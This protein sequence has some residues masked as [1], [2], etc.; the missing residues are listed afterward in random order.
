MIKSYKI[1]VFIAVAVLGCVG[2]ALSFAQDA[3]PSSVTGWTS[4]LGQIQQE[5][6]QLL[7]VNDQLS[8]ER[9]RL[10]AELASLQQGLSVQREKN[11]KDLLSLEQRRSGAGP[12]GNAAELKSRI[13]EQER[14]VERKRADLARLKAREKN[15]ENRVALHK[16]NI[17]ELELEKKTLLLDKKVK[18]EVVSGK[19]MT[20]IQKLE[21]KVISQTEQEKYIRTKIDA[22]KRNAPP[23]VGDAEA[24]VVINA[25][26]KEQLKSLESKRQALNDAQ[27]QL[28][29]ERAALEK[30]KA[31]SKVLSASERRDALR[32]ELA[33]LKE[34]QKNIQIEANVKTEESVD[35]APATMVEEMKTI[36]AENKRITE[37]ITN[38]RENIAVLEYELNS[39]ERYRSEK[40]K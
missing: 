13:P 11:Q 34:K 16:L 26:L 23:Y 24:E 37:E 8:Q 18:E 35:K 7:L 15:V 20:D 36:E 33:A 17:A 4:S 30:N 1:I 40:G 25:E 6:D 29:Q 39:L 14:T 2:A 21:D 19:E 38:L 28:S 9:A 31:V 27:V 12:L 32:T 3:A 22:L 10:N 5:T